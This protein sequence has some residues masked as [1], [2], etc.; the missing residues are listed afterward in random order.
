MM[1]RF[2]PVWVSLIGILD[3]FGAG[4]VIPAN[5]IANMTAGE[6]IEELSQKGYAEAAQEI[7]KRTL[8]AAGVEG[9]TEMAQ[10]AA[11]ISGAKTQGAEYD[12]SEV[13]DRAIDSFVLGGTMGGGTRLGAEAIR[14]GAPD[15][16]TREAAAQRLT[17]LGEVINPVMV[18]NDPQAAAEL[19][20]KLDGIAEAKS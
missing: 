5:K 3:K 8:K 11:V 14:G 7:T 1:P 18:G 12:L 10:D 15:T 13:G 2:Q 17:E 6:I 20:K 4:K 9:G 19:A 16:P